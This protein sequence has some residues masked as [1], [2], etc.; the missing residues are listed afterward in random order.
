M[1]EYEIYLKES[2][3]KDFLKIP[4]KD[5]RKILARIESPLQMIQAHRVTRSFQG[6]KNIVSVKG[7]IELFILHKRKRSLFGS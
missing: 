4:K 6:Q 5:I 7:C 3:E 2:V 1:A